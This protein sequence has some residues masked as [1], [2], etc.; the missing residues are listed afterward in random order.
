MDYISYAIFNECCREALELKR[1]LVEY[2]RDELFLNFHFRADTAE[3]LMQ[4]LASA[5]ATNRLPAMLLITVPLLRA[6]SFHIIRQVKE[7]YP[8]IK[9][10]LLAKTDDEKLIDN[11][12]RDG[13]NGVIPASGSYETIVNTCRYLTRHEHLDNHYFNKSFERTRKRKSR[14]DLPEYIPDVEQLKI[15]EQLRDGYSEKEISDAL[16]LSLDK[17]K[18]RIKRINEGIRNKSGKSNYIPLYFIKRG[19]IENIADDD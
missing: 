10:L 15:A 6:D 2:F 13:A 11:A 5:S 9:I 7:K 16:K 1:M 4:T 14:Y 19:F 17:I 8:E 3:K 18:H 12:F